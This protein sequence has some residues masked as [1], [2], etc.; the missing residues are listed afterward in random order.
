MAAISL[1]YMWLC[2]Q[3]DSAVM[4]ADAC[5]HTSSKSGAIFHLENRL[6]IYT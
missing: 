5:G 4:R 6:S 1:A 2:V 3:S